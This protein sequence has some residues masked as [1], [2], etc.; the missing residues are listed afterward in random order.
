MTGSRFLGVSVALA[1]C[2]GLLGRF[3]FELVWPD[4]EPDGFYCAIVAAFFVSTSGWMVALRGL[5]SDPLR[6]PAWFGIGTLVK[7]ALIGL[8]ILVVWA[9]GLCDLE[10]FLV[11][12]VLLLV[13][14]GLVQMVLVARVALGKLEE[15]ER[16]VSD[17][18]DSSPEGNAT[19]RS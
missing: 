13:I 16:S 9:T 3:L 19:L 11:P 12:F 17:Q 14:L 7:M 8:S 18:S 6:Y 1:I 10:E 2:L 4:V 15:P 5:T